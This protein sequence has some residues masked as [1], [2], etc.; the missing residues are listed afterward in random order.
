[1]TMTM[2][3]MMTMTTD[4]QRTRRPSRSSRRWGFTL[5]EIL[6]ALAILAILLG[7][8]YP[9][10]ATAGQFAPTYT[11]STVVRQVRERIQYHTV[12]ADVPLS[13]EGYPKTLDPAWFSSVQLPVDS[14]THRPLNVQV[15]NGPKNATAPNNKTFV[16]KKDGTAA[17]H[18]AW[19]NAANGSFCVLVPKGKNAEDDLAEFT[20]VNGETQ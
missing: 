15:V 17:G 20:L 7:V 1:M 19:Y 5:I 16:Y 18:T 11:M 4:S 9:M 10:V 6:I 12:L 3:M 2:T 8:V 13:N 14:W